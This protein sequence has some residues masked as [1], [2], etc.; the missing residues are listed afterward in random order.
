MK[1]LIVRILR[2][3]PDPLHHLPDEWAQL[4]AHQN[5]RSEIKQDGPNWRPTQKIF[6][7]GL[8]KT[9]TTSLNYALRKL[10]YESIH[11][12]K[13]GKIL[14][15][16]EFFIADA[17]TDTPCCVQFEALYHTFENSKF[18]YTTRK[19]D[20]WKRS[21]INHFGVEQPEDLRLL[22][23]SKTDRWERWK[24]Y[25][26]IRWIQIHECLYAQYDSW[27]K[28]YAS[29]DK[30]VRSFFED[31][32]QDRLLE[33]DITAGDGWESLCSFLG[34]EN[35]NIPFPHKASSKG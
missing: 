5:A 24:S 14:S 16:P 19:V 28:A 8:S 9:G 31:K 4:R 3:F 1:R 7:I 26:L 32:P 15:W 25:N 21:A 23:P 33:L 20:E 10:G 17:A 34:R 22:Y 2:K 30:R 6:G 18:I 35:P 27:E 29:Y 12:R 11:M 13:Q